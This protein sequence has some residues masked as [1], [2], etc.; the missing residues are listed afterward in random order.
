MATWTGRTV[1]STRREWIIPAVSPW[2]AAAAEVGK[3]WA[4]A[5]RGYREVHGLLGL[6]SDLPDNA[7]QF[8][9][10]DDAIVISFTTDQPA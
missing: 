6:E 9:A 8:H 7:L 3:A 4:A 1:T 10:A 2:G 5:E